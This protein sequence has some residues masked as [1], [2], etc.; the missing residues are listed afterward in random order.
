MRHV[1]EVWDTI[2]WVGA[3]VRTWDS[4]SFGVGA[5]RQDRLD[6]VDRGSGGKTH[7]ALDGDEGWANR[8][9]RYTRSLR[10]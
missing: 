9:V 4:W 10:P 8:Q 1:D 7:R 2:D 6:R 3:R 5:H